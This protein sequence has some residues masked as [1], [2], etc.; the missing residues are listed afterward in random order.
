MTDNNLAVILFVSVIITYLVRY[1]PL[2]TLHSARIPSVVNK[3]LHNLPVA[4]LAAIAFQ[5]VFLKEGKIYHGWDNFYL[6]GLI[7]CIVLAVKTKNLAVTVFGSIS[8]L[9]AL[10]YLFAF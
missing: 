1:L 3:F 10:N 4:I 7:A 2:V 8:L 9:F 5:A 6:I